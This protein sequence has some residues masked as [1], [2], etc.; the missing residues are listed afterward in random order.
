MVAPTTSG[1]ERGGRR[2]STSNIR[3]GWFGG[4]DRWHEGGLGATS[5][6]SM[7]P[8]TAQDGVRTDPKPRHSPKLPCPG[9]T[10][11]T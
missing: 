6:E 3:E 9:M 4:G 10:G 2:T 5:R 8:Q 1:G 7:G 11:Q